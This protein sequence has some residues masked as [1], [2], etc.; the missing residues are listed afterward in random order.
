MERVQ[1]AYECDSKKIRLERARHGLS[2][3]E[4][5]KEANLSPK[6]I[7]RIEQNKVIPRLQTIGKIATALGKDIE[8]FI[9]KNK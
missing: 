9:T 7:I 1:K 3:V 5:A 4:L 8:D 6:T 2:I